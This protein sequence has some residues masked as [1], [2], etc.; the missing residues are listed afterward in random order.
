MKIEQ[1]ARF[2]WNGKGRRVC[3]VCN[4]PERCGQTLALVCRQ[5]LQVSAG[6]AV[7]QGEGFLDI[8]HGKM[9]LPMDITTRIVHDTFRVVNN[10]KTD[11]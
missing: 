8:G 2:G 3:E 1:H 10:S 9:L 6:E 4:P 5:A 7:Q 11:I